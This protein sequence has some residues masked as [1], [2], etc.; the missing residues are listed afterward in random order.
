MTMTVSD[1]T[2]EGYTVQTVAGRRVL[3]LYS[4]EYDQTFLCP[5]NKVRGVWNTGRA[6]EAWLD[7][8]D[9]RFRQRLVSAGP[10]RVALQGQI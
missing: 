4:P 6:Y 5:T 9:S 1:M 8:L 3:A 7:S 2:A 10:D